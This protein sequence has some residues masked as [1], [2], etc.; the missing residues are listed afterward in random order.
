MMDSR[1]ILLTLALTLPGVALA[2]P[3]KSGHKGESRTHT[4]SDSATSKE[5]AMGAAGRQV[6]GR[7]LS[8][9]LIEETP[10]PY[11]KIRV[12]TEKGRVKTVK[13][14]AGRDAE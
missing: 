5:Q 9:D 4:S 6:K 2:A 14:D 11:Y 7:V 8:A 1:T 10:A 12:L 3:G 13:V